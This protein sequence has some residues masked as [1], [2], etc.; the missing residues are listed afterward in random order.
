VRAAVLV[1]MYFASSNIPLILLMILVVSTATV[2]FTP[3]E[4]AM[5][6]AVVPRQQLV[7]ANGLFTLTLNGAFAIGYAFLGP[8]VT[9]LSS[10]EYSIILVA[11]LYGI[12]AIFCSTL[13]PNPPQPRP[14]ESPMVAVAE[15]GRA[16][17]G[18][19][20]QLREGIT[21]IRS[22]PQISWSLFYLGIAGSLIGVIGVLGPSFA[23]R[24]L[25]LDP[26]DLV[27]VVLPLGFGIITGSLLL[28][29][30]GRLMPRRRAIEVGLIALGI[31][32]FILTIAGPISMFLQGLNAGSGV[33][34]SSVTSLVAVVI[35]IAFLAGASYAVVAISSQTQLQE[36][37]PSEVRGR[38][39]GVLNLVLSIGTFVPIIIVGPVSDLISTTPV[40]LVVAVFVLIS[41]IASVLKRGRLQPADYLAT[42][43]TRSDSRSFDAIGVIRPEDAGYRAGRKDDSDEE[44]GP[45]DSGK[46]APL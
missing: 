45:A 42:A 22:N 46:A 19:F 32:L 29:S 18:V 25:G 1:A 41:G 11:I 5:I 26:E 31:L 35:V 23:E 16:V 27:V 44:P 10:P 4:A 9:T 34:L 28:N 30:Y 20:D 17:G 37:I 21:Y 43:Q 6:P 2:F 24:T 33:D 3:A 8:L 13:P 36:D 7:S 39:F 14:R 40:I 12:A 15:T 38:V